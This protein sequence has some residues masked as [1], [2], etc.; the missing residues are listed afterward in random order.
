[1][2]S[3]ILCVKR[4]PVPDKKDRESHLAILSCQPHC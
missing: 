1:V 2:H 3:L 4:E